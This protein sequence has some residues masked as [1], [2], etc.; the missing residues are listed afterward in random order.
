MKTFK[1]LKVHTSKE[2]IRLDHLNVTTI[3]IV[4]CFTQRLVFNTVPSMFHPPQTENLAKTYKAIIHW[5][6]ANFN[7]HTLVAI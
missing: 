6:L 1:R 7:I 3:N 4:L 5:I 2:V